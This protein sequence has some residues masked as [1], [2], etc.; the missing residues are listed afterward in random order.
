[1]S[2]DAHDGPHFN[3]VQKGSLRFEMRFVAALQRTV[4]VVVYD[5]F[6]TVLE[7][8]RSRNVN[9]GSLFTW[10]MKAAVN[11]STCTDCR[12][13]Y[14][15]L[16][17]AAVTQIVPYLSRIDLQRQKTPELLLYR[18]RAV[19]HPVLAAVMSVYADGDFYGGLWN[20]L[21]Q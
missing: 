15:D 8:D 9:T 1:M 7:I 20:R 16:Y 17:V 3:Q 13:E 11:T 14:F 2:P 21:N 19:L 10:R 4:N 12:G 5:E 18:V 6:K